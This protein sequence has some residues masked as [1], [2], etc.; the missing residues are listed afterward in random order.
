M[1]K[2]VPRTPRRRVGESTGDMIGVPMDHPSHGV[3][4]TIIDLGFARMNAGDG[5]GCAVHWTPFD[6]LI[7]EGEGQ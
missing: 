5:S 3:T 7:F 1:R 4:A 2:V 6:E